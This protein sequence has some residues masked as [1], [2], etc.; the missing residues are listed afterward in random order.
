MHTLSWPDWIPNGLASP[1]CGICHLDSSI[2]KRSRIWWE[3]DQDRECAPYPWCPLEVMDNL[4]LLA[5]L[6]VP[7]PDSA[8]ITAPSYSVFPDP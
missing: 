6:P 1:H 4:G 7:I 2:P 5:R 3:G 8:G